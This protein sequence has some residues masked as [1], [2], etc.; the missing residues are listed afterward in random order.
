M[1]DCGSD[2]AETVDSGTQVKLTATAASGH[3]FTGWTGCDSASGA[4]CTQTVNSN[5]TVT[6]N[7]SKEKYKLKIDPKPTN[8]YV[9]G[10]DINCGSG[11]GRTTC[12]VSLKH[13]ENVSL[14]TTA[15]MNYWFKGWIGGPC[16]GTV[17][18][19]T[20]ELLGD[21]TFG[22]DF[23]PYDLIYRLASSKPATPTGG[24]GDEQHTPTGWQRTKPSPAAGQPVW[25]AQRERHYNDE[26]FDKAM[27]W[28]GVAKI[29]DLDFI[30]NET[31]STPATPTGGETV[32]THTPSGWTRALLN[33][34][35]QNVTTF[36]AERVRY[37]KNGRFVRASAW[38]GVVELF[39][40]NAGGPY[41]ADPVQRGRLSYYTAFVQATARG[42]VSPL[43]YRWEG[44]SA[45]SRTAEYLFET[46]GIYSKSVTVTDGSGE[47]R[48]SSATIFTRGQ[49][50]VGGASDDFAHEVPLGG[51]LVFIWGGAG[52]VSATS[53]DAGIATVS[54]S[55]AEIV[56]SGVSAGSTEIVVKPA[57]SEFRVPVRVGGGG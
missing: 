13:E 19:C 6:A 29:E 53:D 52:S 38:G 22:A 1:I 20:F 3:R 44:K 23:Q 16:D 41:W 49:L 9:T 35:N 18:N 25:Q 31:T 45:N 32:E 11:T 4:V 46:S 50:R 10:N 21:T 5:E 7:F 8:G 54:V 27:A 30:Y 36:Q 51:T 42:G 24:T 40:V 2:C 57:G 12:E 37:Y 47:K 56:V 26:G 34:L 17:G 15:D 28:S 33:F 43:S 48:K 14:S 39:W 55:G